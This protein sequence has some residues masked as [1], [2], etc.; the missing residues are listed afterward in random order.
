MKCPFCKLNK[1][2]NHIYLCKSKP[3]LKK[4]EL[5]KEYILYNYPDIS[6]YE[7]LHENYINLK[8][9]LPD[10]NNKF[11]IDFNSIRFLLKL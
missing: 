4:E 7:D 10:I 3:E 8:L 1:R 5:R 11:G 9:S 2:G 6:N